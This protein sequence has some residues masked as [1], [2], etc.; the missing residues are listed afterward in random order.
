MKSVFP[1]WFKKEIY[2]C[3]NFVSGERSSVTNINH[4][5]AILIQIMEFNNTQF[6]R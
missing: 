5:I 6:I 1:H 2:A 3:H 4:M